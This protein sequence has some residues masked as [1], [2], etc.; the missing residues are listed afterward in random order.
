MHCQEGRVTV[1]ALGKTQALEAGWLLELPAGEPH[2]LTGID[3][4]SSILLTTF[5]PAS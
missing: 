2:E 1:T 5:V 4:A 3:D